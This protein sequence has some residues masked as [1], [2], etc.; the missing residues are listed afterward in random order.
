MS[1]TCLARPRKR[2]IR[3]CSLGSEA[4][5]ALEPGWVDGTRGAGGLDVEGMAGGGLDE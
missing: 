1:R 2:P 4:D 3:L 5:G